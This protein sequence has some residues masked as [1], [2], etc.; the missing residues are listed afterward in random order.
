MGRGQYA[1]Y[2]SRDWWPAGWRCE[3]CGADAGAAVSAGGAGRPYNSGQ[4]TCTP[5][6]AAARKVRLQRERRM[7]QR[8]AA[9]AVE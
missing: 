2:R 8:A 4:K 6:C 1:F 7:K 5:A 3:E 9:A